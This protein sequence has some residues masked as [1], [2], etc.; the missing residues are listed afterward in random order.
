[1]TALPVESCRVYKE[2]PDAPL[3]VHL[4]I[5]WPKDKSARN[6]SRTGLMAVCGRFG[7]VRDMIIIGDANT[8]YATFGSREGAVAAATALQSNADRGEFFRG[9][10]F[11]VTA[12]AVV[13]NETDGLTSAADLLKALQTREAVEEPEGETGE[14]PRWGGCR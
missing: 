2:R 13:T 3:D 9:T 14:R 4:C 7:D 6:L 1:M 8:A 11:T 12:A 5:K 10:A